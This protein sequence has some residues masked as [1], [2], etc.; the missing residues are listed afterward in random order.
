MKCFGLDTG[1]LEKYVMSGQR[2]FTEQGKV[3]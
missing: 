2:Y 1:A 3:H